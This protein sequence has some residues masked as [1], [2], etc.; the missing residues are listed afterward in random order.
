MRILVI[1]GTRLVGRHIAQTAI[2]RG[3]DVTLF[4]RG[5]SDPDAMPAATHLT[6]DRNSDLS[7]LE[8]GEW[9]ATIDV[10]AYVHRQV[11]TLLE[12]L[13]ERA[14]H[15]TFISTIS[16]YGQD[17]PN[18]G[19]T[20]TAPLLEPSW[21]DK[22]G[23]DNYGELKVACEEVAVKT[24]P[25]GVLIIRPGYV[26]GPY[27]YSERFTHWVRAIAAK[28]PFVGPDPEQPLQCI[29][30]RD[31]AAFIIGAIER[32][33]TGDF[34]ATAPQQPPTF[35][36]VFDTIAAALDVTLPEVTWSGKADDALPL[37]S[38]RDWWPKMHAD[39]SKA[40]DAGLTW[41]PLSQTVRDLADHISL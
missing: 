5:K 40:V 31:L 11:R 30:G 20:E 26:I 36:Q 13:G 17:V 4:N 35:S 19:F 10:S 22:P 34:N 16:V 24:A 28:Q 25:A 15:F 41:R 7:A 37:S 3:H 9:D 39:V 6:G 29:D 32:G 8:D 1:G 23:M 21:D 38:P 2:D 33:L 14:G 18:R 12:T 27:D